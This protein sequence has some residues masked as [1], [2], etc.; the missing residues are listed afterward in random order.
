MTSPQNT[1][2]TS[3]ESVGAP[4]S[5]PNT[6]QTEGTVSS[7]WRGIQGMN[8]WALLGIVAIILLLI[9]YFYWHRQEASTKETSNDNKY[10]KGSDSSND[11][12]TRARALLTARGYPADQ[13]N[14]AMQH[15]LHG[16]RMSTQDQS[17]V[18]VAIRTLGTPDIPNPTPNNK[19]ENPWTNPGPAVPSAGN[20]SSSSS[21]KLSD[22]NQQAFVY[23]QSTGFGWTSSLRGIAAQ[24]Y[25]SANY[26][27]YLLQYNPTIT[28]VSD[29]IPI[30]TKVTVPTRM[31]V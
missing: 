20:D 19:P 17:L 21:G 31:V 27:S 25:G 10:G 12:E 24:M 2:N 30:G 11:W 22:D 23:V 28:S 9:W 16:G 1:P 7:A 18:S 15:Y 13:I 6:A 3:P 26:A 4:Q 14:S 8:R 5:P 29:R